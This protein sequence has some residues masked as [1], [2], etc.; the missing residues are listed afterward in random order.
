MTCSRSSAVIVP[1]NTEFKGENLSACL[2][3]TAPS[4]LVASPRFERLLN[5][6]DLIGFGLQNLVLK[7]LLP[8]AIGQIVRLFVKQVV[9]RYKAR[10][11]I[12]SNILILLLIYFTIASAAA[13]P[14][15]LKTLAGMAVRPYNFEHIVTSFV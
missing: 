5:Q 3:R 14:L 11:H 2:E 9:I 8:I 1:L 13:N 6:T 15:F 7:M 4:V 12:V 10:L